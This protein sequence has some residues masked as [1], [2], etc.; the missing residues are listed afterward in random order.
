MIVYFSAT[1]NSKYVAERIAAAL[2]EKAVSI[3]DKC[4]DI[5]LEDDECFGKRYKIAFRMEQY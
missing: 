2:N 5:T 4:Y 1:G 3:E